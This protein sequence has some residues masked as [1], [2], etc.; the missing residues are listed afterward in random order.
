MTRNAPA[1]IRFALKQP[2]MRRK[3]ESPT[4]LSR[5]VEE[6]FELLVEVIRELFDLGNRTRGRRIAAEARWIRMIT[7]ASSAPALMV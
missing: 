1:E 5:E 2:A 7:M 6:P 4:S 3:P